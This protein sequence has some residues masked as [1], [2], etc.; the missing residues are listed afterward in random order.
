LTFLT[1]QYKK[2]KI[3]KKPLYSTDDFRTFMSKRCYRFY[4]PN[5][6][7]EE[8]KINIEAIKM[9]AITPFLLSWHPIDVGRKLFIMRELKRKGW[10]NQ[11]G[12]EQVKSTL[13]TTSDI[14]D[15]VGQ[16]GLLLTLITVVLT[17]LGLPLG[18]VFGGF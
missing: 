13:S 17:A 6:K 10:L 16:R 9:C 12:Y 4:C 11:T 5:T 15:K 8:E 1:N 14:I 3:T 7:N 18:M 2:R